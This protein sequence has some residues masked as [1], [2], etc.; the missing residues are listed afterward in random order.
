MN[1]TNSLFLC[2][3]RSVTISDGCD[4]HISVKMSYSFLSAVLF[5]FKLSHDYLSK[6]IDNAEHGCICL[7]GLL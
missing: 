1:N 4:I 2:F 5:Y 7:L 6:S 3:I